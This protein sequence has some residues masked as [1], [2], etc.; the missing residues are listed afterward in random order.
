MKKRSAFV[1]AK[2]LAVRDRGVLYVPEAPFTD[3]QKFVGHY[4]LL[5]DVAAGGSDRKGYVVAG[6][7]HN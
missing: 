3:A 2:G 1:I 6:F 7:L 4:L 5:L